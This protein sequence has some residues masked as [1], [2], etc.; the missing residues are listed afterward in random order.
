MAVSAGE[1]V[2]LNRFLDKKMVEVRGHVYALS[3][4]FIWIMAIIGLADKNI[5]LFNVSY[6]EN[7]NQRNMRYFIFFHVR[8]SKPA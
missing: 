4:I 1:I 2:F 8:K 7:N 5:M 6:L 3:L